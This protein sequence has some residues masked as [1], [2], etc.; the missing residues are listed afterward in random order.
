MVRERHC[1][2]CNIADGG[3][4]QCLL[5]GYLYPYQGLECLTSVC[6]QQ[7]CLE[8]LKRSGVT[9][10]GKRAVVLGRSNI[11]GMP[12][13]HLLQVGPSWSPLFFPHGRSVLTWFCTVLEAVC[14]MQWC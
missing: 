4:L 14:T 10:S 2:F 5:K 9:I 3:E 8:L 13:A 1:Y 6:R 12:V 7:G 11:V